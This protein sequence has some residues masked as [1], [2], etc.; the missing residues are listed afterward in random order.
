ML[1]ILES[2]I[3]PALTIAHALPDVVAGVGKTGATIDLG[4]LIDPAGSYHTMVT[5]HTNFDSNPNVDG[6]QGDITFELFDDTAPLTV[7]NFLSYV[8]NVSK[9][10][11]YTGTFFERL[12]T[13]FVLQ[14]GSFNTNFTAVKT[15]LN[16]HNEVGAQNLA[17]T[18]ALAKIPG[19][20]N[21][22]SAGFFI[23]LADNPDLDTQN[24]GFTVFARVSA[25]MDVVNAIAAL[26]T[27]NLTP[28]NANSGFTTVP[29]QHGYVADPDSNAATPPPI[30]TADQLIAITGVEVLPPTHGNSPGVTY[31][32]TITDANSNVTSTLVTSHLTGDLLTLAYKKGGSGVAK[33]TITATDGTDTVTD[34][35][36]VTVKSNLAVTLTDGLPGAMVPGDDGI[37]SVKVFNNGAAIANTRVDVKVFMTQVTSDNSATPVLI[38]SLN[39]VPLLLASGASKTLSPKIEVPEALAADQSKTYVI[40]ASVTP[41]AGTPLDEL[42][43]DDNSNGSHVTHQLFN[44]FG[45]FN[46]DFGFRSNV[47]LTY[48]D[49]TGHEVTVTLKGG[50]FGQFTFATGSTVPDLSITNTNAAS[51]LATK[52]ISTPGA[53]GNGHTVMG[54]F[55]IQQPPEGEAAR[56]AIGTIAMGQVDFTGSFFA[57]GG[58]K[59]LTL[60][61]LTPTD[62]ASHDIQFGFFGSNFVQKSV[63]SLG[64]VTDFSFAS[65]Q[66]VASLKALSWNNVNHPVDT[67]G[68][69]IKE[70]VRAFALDA[71]SIAGNFEANFTTLTGTVLRSFTVG[72]TLKNA[73]IQAGGNVTSVVLGSVIGS[74]FIAGTTTVPAT[75]GDFS[76]YAIIQNFTVK[77]ALQAGTQVAAGGIGNVKLGS[78]DA[79]GSTGV[80]GFHTDQILK[81]QRGT[82]KLSNLQAANA[83]DVQGNYKVIV[84]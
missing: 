26:A 1:E 19:D 13:N 22:G 36:L 28:G 42:F 32:A 33:V 24:G 50:G 43:T 15:G 25:G 29:T 56:V 12:A 14:G 73:V 70:S 53:T 72:G 8:N 65:N 21:G 83:Y 64:N 9:T 38:G 51:V 34:D 46:T 55:S 16:V 10:G 76:S 54:T 68:N 75:I 47:P 59:S 77:G 74:T 84:F 18:V 7:Q 69:E 80:F 67:N 30:P 39:N 4:N 31:T 71:I 62:G 40:T 49:A 23:N 11:D 6:I 20:P 66:P 45:N 27:V 82:T 37:A 63:I 17:G 5:F 48:H 81:Y 57:A 61:D 2:R 79:T 44:A 3:A 60:G 78:V 35:F 41:T 52:V 58:V